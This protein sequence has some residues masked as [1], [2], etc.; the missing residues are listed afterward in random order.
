MGVNIPV[1]LDLGGGF[2]IVFLVFTPKSLEVNRTVPRKLLLHFFVERSFLQGTPRAQGNIVVS[3]FYI[4]SNL[5]VQ[6]CDICR[7]F[8]FLRL[9]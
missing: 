9:T 3:V 6:A 7:L 4:E 5:K 2:N 1:P 8:F